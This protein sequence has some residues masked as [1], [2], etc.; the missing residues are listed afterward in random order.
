MG[1]VKE[2]TDTMARVELHTNCKT[3]TID[4]TK[5]STNLATDTVHSGSGS[6][7]PHYSGMA[8]VDKC[9]CKSA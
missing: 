2:A 8:L 4:T 1:I 7:T 3:I 6:Q 5:L 9:A